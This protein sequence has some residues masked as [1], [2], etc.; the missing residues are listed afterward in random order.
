MSGAPLYLD[1]PAGPALAL[2]DAAREGAERD[3]AVLI[4]PP[5]GWDQMCSYRPRKAWAEDLAAAGY[6]TLRLDLPGTGDSLQDACAA[7]LLEAW[8]EAVSRGARW[9]EEQTGVGAVAGIGIGLGALLLGRAVE[10]G[11]P[12]GDLVLWDGRARGRDVLRELRAFAALEAAQIDPPAGVAAAPL[13]EGDLQ[14]GGFRVAAETRAALQALDLSGAAR[15]GGRRVLLLKRDGIA[16]DPRLKQSLEAAGATVET[17][18]GRGYNAMMD[19]PQFALAPTRVFVPVRAWLEETSGPVAVAQR[20]ALSPPTAQDDGLR[21]EVVSL[22]QPFGRL[23]GVVAEPAEP[24]DDDGGL[25]AIF[26]TRYGQ[27]RM[28]TEAARRWARGGVPTLRLDLQG[29]FEGDGAYPLH[30]GSGREQIAPL[31]G[32]IRGGLDLLERHGS[33]SRFVLAGLC[34]GA[35]WS[36]SAALEDPRVAGIMLINPVALWWDDVAVLRA[37]SRALRSRITRRSSWAKLLSGRIPRSTLVAMVRPL[38]GQVWRLVLTAP[39][40][41]LQARQSGPVDPLEATLDDLRAAGVE[42]RIVFSDGEPLAATFAARDAEQ[43]ARRW[44]NLGIA[45]LSSRDHTLRGLWAQ[46][47]VHAQLDVWLEELRGGV[48]AREAATSPGPV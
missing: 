1:G 9:L 17:D 5:F 48:G 38:L 47:D 10:T 25:G 26:M 43:D 12:L 44:P 39:A 13:P 16:V 27:N 2:F 37:N 33:P 14:V 15:L 34:A 7:G 8:V 29:T 28:H 21:E 19:E 46:A 24:D 40:R 18:P 4:V 41:R 3:R 32:Q 36:V 20:P 42:V 22:E 45:H 31:V 6:P 11:A 30:Q 35:Q 23:L